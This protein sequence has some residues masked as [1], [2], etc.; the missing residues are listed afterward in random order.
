MISDKIQQMIKEAMLSK[1]D[2][3]KTLLR[4][5]KG[6]I[7]REQNKDYN[8]PLDETAK[9]SVVRK[10]IKNNQIVLSYLKDEDDKTKDKISVLQAE[11]K[12][13]EGFLP[14]SMS[15]EE[16]NTFVLSN[17]LVLP[18]H[19]GQAVGFLMKEIKKHNLIVESYM[20]KEFVKTQ[21]I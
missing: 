21:I 8:T 10:M 1:N 3:S 5:L 17:N 12:I 20:I 14:S 18:K 13:L 2:F 9:I 19:E 16:L 4:T 15:K 6:E 7:E 11:I